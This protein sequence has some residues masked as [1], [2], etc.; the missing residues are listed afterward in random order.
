MSITESN[1]CL[2]AFN[3]LCEEL[4]VSKLLNK[5]EC[6]YWVFESGYKAALEE[7]ITNISAVTKSQGRV[8]LE[9]IYL[10]KKTSLH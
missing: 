7:M 6:Q 3:C 5:E 10:A 1:L 4:S 2:D 9:E 8:S